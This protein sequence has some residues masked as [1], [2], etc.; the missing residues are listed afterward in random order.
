[1]RLEQVREQATSGHRAGQ[2]G[3]GSWTDRLPELAARV[4]DGDTAGVVIA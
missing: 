4:L 2:A 1:M 3:A